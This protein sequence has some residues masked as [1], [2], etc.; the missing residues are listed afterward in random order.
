MNKTIKLLL[1]AVLIIIGSSVA[2]VGFRNQQSSYNKQYNHARME[3]AT[4][5]EELHNTEN[6]TQNKLLNKGSKSDDIH[7]LQSADQISLTNEINT[8]AKKVFT[9]LYNY[10]SMDQYLKAKTKLT[11]ILAPSLLNNQAY[12]PTNPQIIAQLK[13]KSVSS[14][15]INTSIMNNYP[16]AQ[17]NVPVFVIIHYSNINNGQPYGQPYEGF[18]MTYNK[19][20]GKFTQLKSV[21]KFAQKESGDNATTN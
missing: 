5:Q 1:S 16:D 13:T 17:G 6:K 4:L 21:G 7:I 3:L 15:L 19:Q 14:S 18:E 2:F 10:S 11:P 20:E 8:K 12:F 9:A